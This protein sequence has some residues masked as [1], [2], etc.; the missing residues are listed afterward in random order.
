M[1][2]PRLLVINDDLENVK[3][4]CQI[5]ESEGFEVATARSGS[6]GIEA[7]RREAPSVILLDVIMPGLDGW[8]TL[9]KLK[10]EEATRDIP[11][12]VFSTHGSSHNSS[13]VSPGGNG[14]LEARKKLE[15]RHLVAEVRKHLALPQQVPARERSA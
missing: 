4:T 12:V 7:V 14:S 13:D 11:V 9:E 1:A 10:V 8:E 6:E 15:V 2:K 5:L 3:S